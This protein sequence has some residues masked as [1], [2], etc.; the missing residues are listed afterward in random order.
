MFVDPGGA[1]WKINFRFGSQQGALYN[2]LDKK[3]YYDPTT[4][5][6]TDT[7]DYVLKIGE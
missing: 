4:S 6:D 2:V 3:R 1:V 7:D 5:A